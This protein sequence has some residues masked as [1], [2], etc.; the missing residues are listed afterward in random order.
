M[1]SNAERQEL[2]RRIEEEDGNGGS[3]SANG[4]NKDD[5]SDDGES[6]E[7]SM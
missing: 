4:T 2:E 5:G 1:A 7:A 3:P 6:E